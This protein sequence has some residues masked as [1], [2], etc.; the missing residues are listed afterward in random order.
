[1]L[2]LKQGVN[3]PS[4][5]NIEE[6]A[7]LKEAISG[8]NGIVFIDYRGITANDVAMFRV[9]LSKSGGCMKIAK[10]NLISIALKESG[11]EVDDNML[12]EPTAIIFAKE[13]VPSVAKVVSEAAKKNKAMKIKGGYMESDLL[14]AEDVDKVANIP[15]R[16]ALLSMLVAGLEGPVS[17]FV[18]AGQSIISELPY[19]LE[20][21]KD[22][23]SA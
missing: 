7:A 3:M 10:N 14:S 21:V 2:E 1:M 17:G 22:Q 18:G 12:I 8:S 13:D 4:Q 9:E 19:L 15:S 23:K 16:E 11:R 5:K 20:A 6:V